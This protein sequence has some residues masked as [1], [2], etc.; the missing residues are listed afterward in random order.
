MPGRSRRRRPAVGI[1]APAAD[2]EARAV[3]DSLVQRGAE[4][5][6]IDFGGFPDRKTGCLGPSLLRYGGIDLAALGACYLRISGYNWPFDSPGCCASW[7]DR[8]S[9]YRDFLAREVAALSF[10]E[11]LL[12]LLTRRLPVVNPQPLQELHRLKLYQYHLLGRRLIPVAETVAGNDARELLRFARRAAPC[13]RKPIAGILKT[14]LLDS[15]EELRL[16]LTSRPICGQRYL[17]GRTIRCYVVDDR[18][19][20][21]GVILHESAVDSSVAQRGVELIELPSA[22]QSQVRAAARALGLLFSGIDVQ[23]DA[24]RNRYAI[25]E[26]NVSPMFANF[27]KMSGVDVPGAL[28]DLLI[29]L[30]GRRRGPGG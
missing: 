1:V 25:L 23:H 28:A 24:R 13:V 5:R 19:V 8:Y 21:S 27:A 7:P 9:E 29:R 6:F 4:P 12:R 20:A 26:C 2:A 14:R 3:A 11:C 30:A 17:P 22:V 18:L 15:G 16:E 10:K